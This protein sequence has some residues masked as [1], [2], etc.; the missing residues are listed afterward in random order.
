[1]KFS[2]NINQKGYFFA[3]FLTKIKEFEQKTGKKVIDLTVG[4]PTF[5]PS[6]KYLKKLKQLVEKPEVYL[7]PGYRGDV[8]LRS[9]LKNWYKKRF[10]V[11]LTEGN[12]LPVL[13]GKDA[14]SHLPPLFLNPKD[15]VLVPDPGY[16]GFSGTIGFFGGKTVSYTLEEENDYLIDFKKLR[17]K[18]TSQTKAI[19]VNYPHNPTG[20]VADLNFLQ[21]LVDFCF[22]YQITLLYDNAYSE[23]NFDHYQA[24]SIFQIKNAKKIALEIGSFSK[25]F[26]FAGLRIGWIAA[27]KKNIDNFLKIKSQ[28]DSGVPLIFQK[29]ASFALE[30]FDDHWYKK[31]IGYYNSQRK[32]VCSFFKKIVGEVNLPKAGFYLWLKIPSNF[33]DGFELAQFLLEKYQIA[34]TPGLAFGNNGK[35]Y[36]RVSFSGKIDNNELARLI[37]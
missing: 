20:A 5:P 26:S 17:K 4:S 25:M 30:N 29:L 21:D 22:E 27:D 28:F 34:V 23:I 31:M 11:D 24:P 7:Y 1:M 2:Q 18:I 14:I 19:F 9:A 16:P 8:E 37:I 33:S 15:E 10:G 36:I 35:K 3:D 6:K 12:F 13:G 32:I